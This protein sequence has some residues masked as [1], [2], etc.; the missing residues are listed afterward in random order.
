MNEQFYEQLYDELYRLNYINDDI[1]SHLYEE[2]CYNSCLIKTIEDSGIAYSTILDVG[3]GRGNGI[4]NLK[5][6]GK[7]VFGVEISQTAVNAAKN[8]GLNVVQ[9]S[10]TKIPYEDEKFELVTSTDVIEHLY[11]EDVLKALKE[12]WRVS[13]K[14]VALKIAP[15]KER[16]SVNLLDGLHRLNKYINVDNLHLTTKDPEYWFDILE[17]KAHFKII[18]KVIDE[19]PD[20]SIGIHSLRIILEK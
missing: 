2:S 19:H 14:Y 1:H 11:E 17:N 16:G 8:K 4:F 7:E 15:S 20:P 10:I 3:C 5:K 6:L 9:G 13:K 18:K 12:L